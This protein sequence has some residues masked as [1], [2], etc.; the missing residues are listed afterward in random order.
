MA[1]K[2]ALYGIALFKNHINLDCF[3]GIGRCEGRFF[4]IK[5]RSRG[6]VIADYVHLNNQLSHQMN[7]FPSTQAVWQS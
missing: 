4:F 1:I 2:L 3:T 5:T 6:D 7:Y